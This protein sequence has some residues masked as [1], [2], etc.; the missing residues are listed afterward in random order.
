METVTDLTDDGETAVDGTQ[1][2]YT[3]YGA[4]TAVL[5]GGAIIENGA[6]GW[7]GGSAASTAA[8]P[9]K[10][11]EAGKYKLQINYFTG[12]TRNITVTVNGKAAGS[13]SCPSTG[14]YTSDSADSIYVEA[15]LKKGTNTIKLGNSSG[16]C[17]NI[18]SIGVSKTV[19]AAVSDTED[20]TEKD[21]AKD[22]SASKKSVQKVV[23]TKKGSSKAITKTITLKRRKKL[24]LSAK[25]TVTGGASKKV[26][27]KSSNKK[28]AA[29][30]SNGIVTVKAKKGKVKIT[31]VSKADKKKKYTITIKI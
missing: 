4:D 5:A 24:Q 6:V 22:S 28:I 3:I 8:F 27:W 13:Y 20:V 9:V 10:V 26:T 23:I 31:A 7:L 30:S 12:E 17:P 19:L 18:S 14:S 2:D 25:V 16:W 29:V 1:Y 15:V 11:S 21:T